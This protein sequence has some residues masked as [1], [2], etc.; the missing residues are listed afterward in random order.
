MRARLRPLGA[1]SPTRQVV[2]LQHHDAGEQ[3][4]ETARLAVLLAWTAGGVDAIGY[5]VLSHLFTAHMSGNTVGFGVATGQGHWDT[6]LERGMT[7]VFF[8]IGIAAG[9]AI[10][11]MNLKRGQRHPT[12]AVFGSEVVLLGAFLLF[13]ARVI[14][15]GAIPTT[16][17]WQFYALVALPTLAMGLQSATLRKVGQVRIHTTYVTGVLTSLMEVAVEFLFWLR[18]SRTADSAEAKQQSPV[19]QLRLYGSVMLAYL[20]GA[21]LGTVALTQ[22]GLG[23]VL[24][25]IAGLGVA[26][27]RDL[28]HPHELAEPRRPAPGLPS[29]QR[30]R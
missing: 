20:I 10:G 18:R 19:G 21:V 12:V 7:I 29:G 17:A 11:E 14:V 3:R 16:P 26:I 23:S 9:M 4:P 6:M 2:G 5:V 15:D 27:A 8:A 28:T 1:L 24:L 30:P 25:P 13:G 22:W